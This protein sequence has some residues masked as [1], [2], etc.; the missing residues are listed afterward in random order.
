[1]QLIGNVSAIR[2]GSEEGLG[3]ISSE[4]RPGQASRT[5]SVHARTL[6]GWRLTTAHK[7]PGETTSHKPTRHWW[8]SQGLHWLDGAGQHLALILQPVS[9]C[10][11]GAGEREPRWRAP[12]DMHNAADVHGA[13]PLA[14]LDWVGVA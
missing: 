6:G 7:L 11:H 13:R 9:A 10:C 12:G 3:R 1:M 5:G 2:R 4:V 8:L 14:A